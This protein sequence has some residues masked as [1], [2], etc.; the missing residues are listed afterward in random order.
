MLDTP[1]RS[2]FYRVGANSGAVGT[3]QDRVVVYSEQLFYLEHIS[4]STYQ[5]YR[6]GGGSVQQSPDYRL[7]I[8][9]GVT[10]EEWDITRYNNDQDIY[11]IV[12]TD[13]TSLGWTDPGGPIGP[14]HQVIYSAS[15]A[16]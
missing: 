16:F 4:G 12:A 14:N 5:I 7:V 6:D 9:Q 10:P 1:L 8:Q 3:V 11:T 2:G 13:N 15:T